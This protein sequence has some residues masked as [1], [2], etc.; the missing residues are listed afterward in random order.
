MSRDT[1]YLHHIL[2]ALANVRQ[3]EDMRKTHDF[4]AVRAIIFE[5]ITMG[6]AARKVSDA[7]RKRYPDVPWQKIIGARNIMVHE[8]DDI[9][10]VAVNE[11]VENHLSPLEMQLKVILKEL[12]S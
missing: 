11:I 5:L 10:Y 7:T 8:Y 1:L 6:A 12:E 2:D 4:T 3:H 9:S